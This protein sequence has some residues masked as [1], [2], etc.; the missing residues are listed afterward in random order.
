MCPEGLRPS[1]AADRITLMYLLLQAGVLKH[2]KDPIHLRKANGVEEHLISTSAYS[3]AG[4]S[5]KLRTTAESTLMPGPM[6]VVM[7][8]DLM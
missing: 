1:L 6:V 8:T 3:A 5:M 4:A 2:K 7:V